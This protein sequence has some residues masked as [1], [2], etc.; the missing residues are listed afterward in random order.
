[1][2][3]KEK[4]KERSKNNE[5]H[6]MALQQKRVCGG[7]GQ[8]PKS[9]RSQSSQLEVITKDANS[10]GEGR[11]PKIVI[12]GGGIG[13]LAAAVAL[14]RL[15]INVTVYECDMFF[16]DRKQGYGLTLSNNRKGPLQA[17][18]LLDD[19]IRL[20]CASDCH[21]VFRPSGEIC[22]Y[23]GRRFKTSASRE[24]E[25]SETNADA[26]DNSNKR[27]RRLR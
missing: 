17:L 14:Q 26:D 12:I 13:G 11:P 22:G 18:G 24:Q 23:Y 6:L 15:K 3:R 10:H 1:M 8:E 21:Y 2:T 9:A 20:D 5:F 19:C 25:E 16:N 27:R 4:R 7:R